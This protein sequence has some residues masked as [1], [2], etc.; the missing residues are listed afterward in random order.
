M[1]RYMYTVE[2]HTQ[3]E[4]PY[5]PLAKDL[6]HEMVSNIRSFDFSTVGQQTTLIR[7]DLAND[8][9]TAEKDPD[10]QFLPFVTRLL[11]EADHIVVMPIKDFGEVGSSIMSG[12]HQASKRRF[13]MFLRPM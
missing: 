12:I 7:Q 9:S 4:S 6:D 2:S 1:H 13:W 8:G 3:V 11:P 10:L 5:S